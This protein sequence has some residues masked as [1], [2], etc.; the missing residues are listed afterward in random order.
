MFKKFTPKKPLPSPLNLSVDFDSLNTEEIEIDKSFHGTFHS[1]F[2]TQNNSIC[3]I[4]KFIIEEDLLELSCNHICHRDCFINNILTCKKCEDD[5]IETDFL[6]PNVLSPKGTFN[7]N[8]DKFTPRISNNNND[9]IID[10]PIMDAIDVPMTPSDQIIF[11]PLK[12]K[13]NK[14]DRSDLRIQQNQL[15]SPRTSFN[16]NLNKDLFDSLMKPR[17]KFIEEFKDRKN[18]FDSYKDDKQFNLNYLLNIKPPKFLNSINV[19]KNL[20]LKNAIYDEIKC[21]ILKNINWNDESIDFSNLGNLIIF[22]IIDIS[23]NGNNW[24]QVR[25][26]LFENSLLLIDLKGEILIGQIFIH[27]INNMVRFLSGIRLNLDNTTIPE[28][29]ICSDIPLIIS[30]LEYYFKKLL[31]HQFIQETSIY[32]LTIN[33]WNIIKD[34][35]QNLPVEILRFQ[36]C[37]ENN[38]EIPENLLIKSMPSPEIIPFNLIISIT[39]LNNTTLSN[40]DYRVKIL[41]FLDQVRSNLRPFDKISLIFVGLNGSGIPCRK[42]SFIGSIEPN[43][44]GWDSIYN[45]VKIQSN[46]NHKN[47]QILRNGFDELSITLDKCKDLFPFLNSGNTINKLIIINSN[48][49]EPEE[50]LVNQDKLNF[51]EGQFKTLLNNEKNLSVDFFRIGKNYTPELEFALKTVLQPSLINNNDV[52]K[53]PYGSKILRFDDFDDFSTKFILILN[54]SFKKIVLPNIQIDIL[55]IIGTR[56]MV[57]FFKIEVHGKLMEINNFSNLKIIMNNIEVN[58]ESNLMVKLKVDLTNLKFDSSLNHDTEKYIELPLLSYMTN[59]FNETDD[60]KVLNT[61]IY[62]DKSTTFSSFLD[63]SMTPPMNDSLPNTLT[64]SSSPISNEQFFDSHVT[65]KTEK[66]FRKEIEIEIIKNLKLVQENQIMNY[67]TIFKNLINYILSCKTEMNFKSKFEQI[68]LYQYKNN[69]NFENF[70]D[71]LLN[72]LYQ[73]RETFEENEPQALLACKDFT[74]WLV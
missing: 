63:G 71:Y 51:I 26:L 41:K 3:T 29:Q 55:K 33:G 40:E 13:Q 54:E 43:W 64:P 59:W 11:D 62:Q 14:I 10:T 66:F 30:R 49:Y 8:N 15:L 20:Q 69:L 23:T 45:E 9:M 58:D 1:N 2:K 52:L 37:I 7:S 18:V 60:Y 46:F 44:S 73:L 57:E 48:I 31:N 72:K 70:I 38:L 17:V 22:E 74:N 27:N 28:L 21:D 53:I 4:C 56:D 36:N 32:Q 42:G 35:Y 34:N 67:Q 24:D 39:L 16:K 68:E 61:K 5:T 12:V 25:L 47:Q 19:D 50:Q 6:T 65:V